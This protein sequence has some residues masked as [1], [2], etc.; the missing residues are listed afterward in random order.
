MQQIMKSGELV[1]T[2]LAFGNSTAISTSG[3]IEIDLGGTKEAED[4]ND[5]E[6]ESPQEELPTQHTATFDGPSNKKDKSGSAQEKKGQQETPKSSKKDAKVKEVSTTQ[7]STSTR[8]EPAEE[9]NPWLQSTESEQQSPTNELKA[10]PIAKQAKQAKKTNSKKGIVDIE[11]AASILDAGGAKDSNAKATPKASGTEEGDVAEKKITM[12]SQAELIRRAFAS[13]DKEV[14]EEFQKEKEAMAGENDPTRQVAKD[15]GP[16][17]VAGW[18]SWVGVGA[19]PPPSNRKKKPLPKKLQAPVKKPEETR[20]RKDDGKPDVIINQK[21]LKKFAST[22][23][24]GDVPHPY[25]SRVEYEQAM[26][27]G[28]GREW[29]VSSS[30]KDMT[31]PEILTRPGKIIQPISKKAKVARAPA[32]F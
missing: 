26:L 7:V 22:F 25:S 18:G 12:L 28:V 3:G 1:A 4:S 15:K 2:S 30:F 24:L 20:K 9:V 16:K 14:E 23:L 13:S 5:I 32:K 17:E 21:R 29:N 31:R 6:T 8:T 19:P 10:K 11:G 27:G